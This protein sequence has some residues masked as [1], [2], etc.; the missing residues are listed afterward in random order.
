M[1]YLNRI[2]SKAKITKEEEELEKEQLTLK[3][4]INKLSKVI[5]Q[6]RKKE[7]QKLEE[8]LFEKEKERSIKIQQMIS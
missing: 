8:Y 7:N 4:E 3:P 1:K 5:A 2:K 6:G